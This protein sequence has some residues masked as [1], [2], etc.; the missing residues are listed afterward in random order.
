MNIKKLLFKIILGIISFLVSVNLLQNYT[1]SDQVAYRFFYEEI[2]GLSYWDVGPVAK[3]VIDSNEPIS[4]FIL[5]L[6]SYVGI[7]KDVWISILNVILILGLFALL[8]RHK[9]PWYVTL[10]I[11]TNF[12]II[13]LITSAERLKISYIILIFAF[14]VASYKRY[15]F[16]FLSTFAHLQSSIFLAGLVLF[17]LRGVIANFV[18]NF[19]IKRKLLILAI[20]LIIITI[21]QILLLE[22]G[23][24]AK[25]NKYL[26]PTQLIEFSRI[27][28]LL[29]LATIVTPNK[30]RM[31]LAFMPL[32]LAVA[33]FGG[34]RVNMVA[35]TLAL[36]IL[37]FEQRLKHPLVL[38][39][40]TYFS[41]KSILFV[42]EIYI[43][44]E[45]FYDL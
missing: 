38:F 3:S 42:Y 22:N 19:K 40:L 2:A 23:I 41:L 16:L 9:A 27:T 43:H 10:L 5:W 17:S 29:G 11:L 20:F 36:G 18:K 30:M 35:V 45:G 21:S 39:L 34:N 24:A 31:L 13:V 1:G 14:L 32:F 4:W 7:D 6:G 15:I 8:L 25:F 28:I 12:Y 26:K 37:M 33:Y 44:G